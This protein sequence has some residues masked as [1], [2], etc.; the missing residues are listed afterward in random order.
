M[1]SDP[2]KIVVELHNWLAPAASNRIPNGR[3][4][5]AIRTNISSE[6]PFEDDYGYAR[7]VRVGEL[8][9]V[10]GTTARPATP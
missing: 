9:F 6:Y 4:H 5:M 3:S 1:H 8:V 7:A 2:E 10:S